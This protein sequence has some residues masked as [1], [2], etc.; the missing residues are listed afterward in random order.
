MWHITPI[1]RAI[2]SDVGCS[3][4][5]AEDESKHVSAINHG[6]EVIDLRFVRRIPRAV[7][8]S[9]AL[10]HAWDFGCSKEGEMSQIH[11]PP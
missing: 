8:D 3:V 2:S 4:G 6:F 11:C 5:I 9:A 7:E 10:L 1:L